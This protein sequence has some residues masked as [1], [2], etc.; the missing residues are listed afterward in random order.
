MNQIDNVAGEKAPDGKEVS[1]VETPEACLFVDTQIMKL[2]GLRFEIVDDIIKVWE[3]DVVPDETNWLV[4][5]RFSQNLDASMNVLT[6]LKVDVE[7]FEEQG[8]HWAVVTFGDEGEL[9]TREANTKE[10]A[11]A[12]ALYAALF[13]RRGDKS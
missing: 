6:G 4:G 8:F 2:L 10:M 3:R 9:E 5:D 13:G 1:G 7:F 11:G 12:F